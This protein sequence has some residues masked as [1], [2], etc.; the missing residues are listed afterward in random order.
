MVALFNGS[1]IMKS[2]KLIVLVCFSMSMVWAA[3]APRNYYGVQDNSSTYYQQRYSGRNG[4]NELTCDIYN[5]ADRDLDFDVNSMIYRL[6]YTYIFTQTR[7]RPHNIGISYAEGW[8]D[9]EPSRSTLK[10]SIA[11]QGE[12]FF[13]DGMSLY[14]KVAHTSLDFDGTEGGLNNYSMGVKYY[15][16]DMPTNVILDYGNIDDGSADGVIYKGL[17]INIG[18]IKDLT[19]VKWYIGKYEDKNFIRTDVCIPIQ[20]EKQYEA[21]LSMSLWYVYVNS[22]ELSQGGPPVASLGTMVGDWTEHQEWW[23]LFVYGTKKVDFPWT[24]VF[25]YGFYRTKEFEKL[26]DTTMMYGKVQYRF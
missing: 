4:N 25:A 8:S 1:N 24:V 5:Y 7:K 12:Y 2:I 17:E 23:L 15:E 16:G 10:S 11:L 20:E 19:W 13:D 18:E 14:G 22:H 21:G 26:N 3:S 6:D 9:I